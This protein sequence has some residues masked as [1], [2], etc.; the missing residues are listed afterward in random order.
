M[1]EISTK[2][3]K[4]RLIPLVNK[5]LLVLDKTEQKKYDDM[6]KKLLGEKESLLLKGKEQR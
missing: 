5:S 2:K 4:K 6:V 1:K 3:N